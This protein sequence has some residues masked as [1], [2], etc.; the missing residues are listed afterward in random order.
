MKVRQCSPAFEI[1][2]INQLI[3]SSFM[4]KRNQSKQI[5]PRRISVMTQSDESWWL[6]SASRA[7]VDNDE[8]L[9][10]FQIWRTEHGSVGP[11]YLS[12]EIIFKSSV[13]ITSNRPSSE[14]SNFL[15]TFFTL[16]QK[17]CNFCKAFLH[18]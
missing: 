2:I 18:H 3:K 12:P 7:L 5:L 6:T 8:F 4:G 17:R 10:L 9:S 16:L 13:A 14:I 1:H 11:R 15:T